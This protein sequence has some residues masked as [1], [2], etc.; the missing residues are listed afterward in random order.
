VTRTQDDLRVFAK[1]LR[2]NS[3]M[4]EDEAKKM[5]NTTTTTNLEKLLPR[6][7]RG[8][9]G[10]CPVL[11]IAISSN[12]FENSPTHRLHQNASAE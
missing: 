9:A 6:L 4:S 1:Q 8:D 10:G 5:L 2:L 11:A 3:G 12:T 7:T